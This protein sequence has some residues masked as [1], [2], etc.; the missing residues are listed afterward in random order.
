MKKQNILRYDLDTLVPELTRAI[1]DKKG[2]IEL[3]PNVYTS[4][5]YKEYF[6][7]KGGPRKDQFAPSVSIDGVRCVRTKKCWTVFVDQEGFDCKP[8]VWSK[9]TMKAVRE[10]NKFMAFRTKKLNLVI[11]IKDNGQ[12][13]F[14]RKTGLRYLSLMNL[15]AFISFDV[16]HDYAVKLF[17]LKSNLQ[18]LEPLLMDTG[19]PRVS[20]SNNLIKDCGS[21]KQFLNNLNTT[22]HPLDATWFAGINLDGIV[23]LMEAAVQ[24]DNPVDLFKQG[25]EYLRHKHEHSEVFRLLEDYIS[26]A[27][28][29]GDKPRF[30]LNRERIRHHHDKATLK[31]LETQPVTHIDVH[32]AAYSF[33]KYL[34]SPSWEIIKDG[35][36]LKQEGIYQKHC[37]ASYAPR[38]TDGECFIISTVLGDERYTGEVS[39]AKKNVWADGESKSLTNLEIEQFRG[40]GNKSVPL[41]LEAALKT[42]VKRYN[43]SYHPWMNMGDRERVLNRNNTQFQQEPQMGQVEYLND[44][45]LARAV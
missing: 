31:F 39:I 13:L 40:F 5:K 38:I 32:P 11:F 18:W 10:G 27:V 34:P 45:L 4:R 14:R 33:E 3:S 16:P 37:V 21:F 7:T 41:E 24:L 19:Y 43:E 29:M 6:S 8:L 9:A 15:S 12:V 22:N 25:K 36:R 1:A 23:S 30:S 17:T 26:M 42:A 20:F 35:K 44:Q 28:M 2:L